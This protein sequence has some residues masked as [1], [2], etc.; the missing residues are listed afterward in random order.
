MP[1]PCLTRRAAL[2]LGALTL[3]HAAAFAKDA[4]VVVPVDADFKPAEVAAKAFEIPDAKALKGLRR[5][6]VTVFVV[7]FV[8]AD[9]VHAQTSGFGAA[10]RANSSLYYRL[11]GVGQPEFQ[12]ITDRL[13]ADFVQRLAASGVE[14]VPT[15]QLR[16]APQ[17]RKMAEGGGKLPSI[18]DDRMLLGAAGLGLFGV[19]RMTP[20]AKGPKTLMGALSSI[21]EGY[22]AVADTVSMHELATTLEASLLEVRVRVNFVELTNHNKGFWGRM[23]NTASTSGKVGP[24]IEGVV[25]GVQTG[26][27]RATLT[28]NQTLALEP[29]AFADVREKAT[30]AGDVAGAVLVGL[31]KLASKSNDTHSSKEMEAVADPTRYT[32]VVGGGL[33][34][35][36]DVIVARLVA[37]R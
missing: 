2:L 20:Q 19:A 23:S 13:H 33:A 35:L 30:T 28:M 4:P 32:Q 21:G 11:L 17:Y 16:A 14:V 31:I 8:T 15:E 10:G 1:R 37:E 18:S 7:E 25:V 36:A 9:A 5:A 24:A 6:A 26:P 12:A 3:A 27:Q 29:S 22:A 34:S